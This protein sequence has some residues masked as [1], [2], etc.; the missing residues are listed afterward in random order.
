MLFDT[1]F[2]ADSY[3]S[4]EC[5]RRSPWEYLTLGTR[6]SFYLRNFAVFAKAGILCKQGKFTP[7][8]QAAYAVKNIRIVESCGGK[9]HLRGLGNLSRF[10]EPAVII[11]NHMSLLETALMHAFVR[12]RRDFC[13]IIKRSLLNVPFFGN[14]MR[15]LK[16][17]P[18]D[19]AN[20]RDDFKTVMDI[21]SARLNEGKSIII[22]PQ[23]TR[24]AVLRPDKFNSIGVKLA[25]HAKAP[26]IPL[27]L[28][29]D[30]LANGKAPFKDLGPLRRERPVWFEFGKPIMSV[31]GSGRD[32]H[33]QI[34]KFIVEH[35]R[36]W[37]GQVGANS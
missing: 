34:V 30:F 37:G 24:S 7:V 2:A 29:T 23:S 13:F 8:L 17:I 28:R 26:V 27:A 3:D 16:C 20:P 15:D 32:E 22:F 4:P 33:A 14:I 1:P 35:V 6:L 31:T 10:P 25:K 21:G 9:I 11:A 5:V 18:L 36:S 12:P 19:R